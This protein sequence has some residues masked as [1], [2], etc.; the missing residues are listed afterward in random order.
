MV[1]IHLASTLS[2]H[3]TG[4]TFL[5]VTT[6]AHKSLLAKRSSV[7]TGTDTRIPDRCSCQGLPLGH[8]H[9]EP[10]AHRRTLARGIPRRQLDTQYLQET[11]PLQGFKNWPLSLQLSC[12]LLN[13]YALCNLPG[14]SLPHWGKRTCKLN[15]LNWS[16][17]SL[18]SYFHAGKLYCWATHHPQVLFSKKVENTCELARNACW[19]FLSAVEMQCNISN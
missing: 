5:S 16:T 1:T 13:A 10:G 2:N 19:Y 8:T 12:H 4:S 11:D 9:A 15:F 18:T 6:W 3:V 14:S 17:A 7:L